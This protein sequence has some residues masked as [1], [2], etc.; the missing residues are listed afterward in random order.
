MPVDVMPGARRRLDA[1]ETCAIS[2]SWLVMDRAV[3]VRRAADDRHARQ[4][5]LILKRALSFVRRPSGTTRGTPD[6]ATSYEP[7]AE[8]PSML[9]KI[10]E[11]PTSFQ[12]W[13]GIS[14]APRSIRRA[15]VD[16]FPYVI[17]FEVHPE[18]T[19]VLAI[20]HAK[21]LPLHW[22]TRAL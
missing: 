13:P 19:L 9:D 4:C 3:A 15:I 5:N 11:A 7:I 17:A 12:I 21:R 14:A 2:V 10:G 20:A 16:R 22:R 1:P 8:V 6:W 18:H